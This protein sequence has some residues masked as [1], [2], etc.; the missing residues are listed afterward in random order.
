ML[1][2]P[3]VQHHARK[4]GGAVGVTPGRGGRRRSGK[5]LEASTSS[6]TRPLTALDKHQQL[7]G[8]VDACGVAGF[9]T[10]LIAAGGAA[11]ADLRAVSVSVCLRMIQLLFPQ[12]A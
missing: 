3:L 7:H 4:P 8:W 10:V 11:G 12:L 6:T 2:F 1:I 9:P 5:A